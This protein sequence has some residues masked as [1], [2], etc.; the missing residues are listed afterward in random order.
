M[1]I[2]FANCHHVK[3]SRIISPFSERSPTC[4]N[5]FPS[6]GT[7]SRLNVETSNYTPVSGLAW[8][9]VV[10]LYVHTTNHE[11]CA[12]VTIIRIALGDSNKSNG[13]PEIPT[14]GRFTWVI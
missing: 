1:P 13:G 4:E 12:L 5:K 3:A 7:R 14:A 8:P 9:I 10:G 11:Y 6:L 2:H